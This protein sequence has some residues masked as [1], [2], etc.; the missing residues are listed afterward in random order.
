MGKKNVVVNNYLADKERFADLFNVV[1]FEGK[2]V[3]CADDLTDMDTKVWRVSQSGHDR[4]YDEFV[5][6]QLKQWK[7]GTRLLV[8]GLEP[9]NEVH[10]ALPVK[11]MNYESLQYNRNYKEIKKK[12]RERKDL[13]SKEYVSGFGK[14][15]YLNPVLTI[16]LYHGKNKWDAPETLHEMM[17]FNGMPEE[18]R[19]KIKM[20]CNDFRIHLLDVNK[21]ENIERYATD[22]REVFGFLIRQNDK[23]ALKEYV[24][25]NIERGINLRNHQ[26]VLEMLGDHQSVEKIIKYTKLPLDY[27]HQ[28][29]KKRHLLR[30]HP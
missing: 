1:I 4:V 25:T 12:H 6:D 13:S 2:Q 21:M 16:V 24:G 15:D 10:Y 11:L 23:N 22:L 27:I 28:V 9:E 8:L 5:R 7:Y 14:N 3:V 20:Y 18:I 30:F 19:E 17:D 29:E 26:I